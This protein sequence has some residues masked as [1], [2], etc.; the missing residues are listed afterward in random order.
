MNFFI[1]N[2]FQSRKIRIFLN[3]VVFRIFS[4]KNMKKYVKKKGMKQNK[5][6]Q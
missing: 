4:Q 2:C 1:S 3:L 5:T 6:E